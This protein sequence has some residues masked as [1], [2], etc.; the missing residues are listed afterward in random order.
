MVP[1]RIDNEPELKI[2]DAMQVKG[3][4][5]TEA[6]AARLA[7]DQVFRS[8]DAAQTMGSAESLSYA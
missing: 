4:A 5:A 1:I 3:R 6:S 8:Q 7:K 2:E